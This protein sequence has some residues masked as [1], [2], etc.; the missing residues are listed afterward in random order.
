M[1]RATMLARLG[2]EPFDVLIVGGG[3]TGLGCAV[4]AAARGYRT[5]LVEA[6]DFAAGTSS[7]STKLVHGGVRYLAQGNLHLVREAL[8]ERALL[9]RNAPHLVTDRTFLTPAYR[10]Y[11]APYYF[12]GLTLYDRLAGAG[13]PFGKSGF[14]SANRTLETLPWLRRAGLRGAIAY[15]DGQF[16][17]ARLAIALAKTAAAHGAAIA[18]Y[19]RC[20]RLDVRG[21]V[22]TLR[23][24]E[25]GTTFELRAR[26]VVNAAGIFAD[27]IRRMDDPAAPALLSLSR[28]THVTVARRVLPGDAALLVPRTDDGR[29]VFAIPW[30]ERV[31]I[32]TTDV[33]VREPLL[34]PQPTEAEIEYLLR[35]VARYASVPLDRSAIAASFAGLRPLVERGA[36]AATAKLSREHV[37]DVAR[38][39]LV[40]IAGGKWTTYRKMAQDA[41]DAAAV[42][43]GLP[44]APCRTERLRLHDDPSDE[45]DALIAADPSLGQPLV[46]GFAYRRADAANGFRNEMARTVDDVVARRTRLAFLDER[47]AAAAR[48]IVERLRPPGLPA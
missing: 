43:A 23:D 48:P 46:D 13:D 34:D 7:R 9:L 24:E 38:S 44:H 47:A 19:V 39:G 45:I 5:A 11:E 3:A 28:G 26:A 22:A 36:A 35:T 27:A 4:D 18:N 32:G 20:T 33:P 10:W 40:T 42:A 2:D 25:R 12:A 21:G 30:H 31:L 16:D 41:I 37:V 14:L 15:H 17:D 6:A 1:N 8:H 29:V